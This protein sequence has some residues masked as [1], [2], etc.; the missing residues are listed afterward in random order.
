MLAAF[1]MDHGVFFCVLL[2]PQG[3]RTDGCGQ[4]LG[5]ASAG[6]GRTGPAMPRVDV[7]AG[8]RRRLWNQPDN[9]ITNDNDSQ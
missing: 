9:E 8:R 1:D 5:T 2:R 4:A 3:N 6:A 7:V